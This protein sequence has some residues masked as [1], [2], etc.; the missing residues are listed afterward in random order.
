MAHAVISDIDT[1]SVADLAGLKAGDCIVSV[2]NEPLHDI[3][4]WQWM[5]AEE[6]CTLQVLRCHE[7]LTFDLQRSWDEPW[8]I[9][10]QDILFDDVHICQ[11][12]CTF[13]FMHQLPKGLRKALYMRD[14]DFRL[15]FLQ[16][17][18]VTLTNLTDADVARII[19]QR[20]SPLRV[21]L[22]AVDPRLR[23]ELI[24]T[25]AAQ[26][27]KNL[28]ALIAGGISIDA[29]IVLVPGVNDGEQLENTLAWCYERPDIQNVAVVPLGYTRFQDCF[30]RGFDEPEEA[31]FVLKQLGV[32]QQKALNER[33]YA[34][35]YAADEFYL[36][37]YGSHALQ[38]IPSAELYDDFTMF[39]DGIGIVRSCV[40]EFEEAASSG[41]LQ[42][43]AN[44]LHEQHVRL[45]F[46]YGQ[47]MSAY[48]AHL[49][50]S[51]PLADCA[52][53]LFVPNDFFGGNVNVTGLLTGTD[54]VHAI[55]N[56]AAANSDTTRVM[57]ALPAVAFNA[58]NL[59]LDDYTPQRVHQESGQE[60]CVAPSNPLECFQYIFDVL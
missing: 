24:G 45:V 59:T 27:I 19:E 15:S 41:L 57:Y 34:W 14:D 32:W 16:G 13:C 38:H 25:R 4:D 6:R 51:S 3:L 21:S 47:A 31:L 39:E 18:F 43:L 8:G 17:N 58:D 46:V 44:T 60:I 53:T 22:H 26:G 30:T 33:G 40:S 54:M 9:S 50:G 29:Q 23:E 5:S 49:F 2:N 56:H 36:D 11:N 7:H 1:G 48:A 52:D 10:F 20:I 42:K 28:E 55:M 12:K 35:V 37:A